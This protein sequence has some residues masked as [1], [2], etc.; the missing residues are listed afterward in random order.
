MGLAASQ[1][2]LLF[3]TSRQSD[4]SAQMQRISQQNIVLAR[5]SDEVSNTYDRMIA[6]A[7]AN[8]STNSTSASS[9]TSLVSSGS[10]PANLSYDYMMGE[11]GAATGKA[12]Y[13]LTDTSNRVVLS[14]NM[15]TKLG[16]SGTGTGHDFGKKIK[17]EEFLQKIAGS[18][19]ANAYR[20][21]S[22]GSAYQ[23]SVSINYLFS[24]MSSGTYVSPLNVTSNA[25]TFNNLARSNNAIN[26]FS[27]T[28]DGISAYYA[29]D[30]DLGKYAGKNW[31][32]AR[33]FNIS[34]KA[35]S[36]QELYNLAGNLQSSAML[37]S[38]YRASATSLPD[39]SGIKTNLGSLVNSIGSQ[40]T[41]G[42]AGL[43][44]NTDAVSSAVKTSTQAVSASYLNNIYWDEGKG[45]GDT[46]DN[47]SKWKAARES[48][49]KCIENMGGTWND[50]WS[51]VFDDANQTYDESAV[52]IGMIA[53]TNL[54]GI[55]ATRCSDEGSNN[56]WQF[57]V[58]AG[59]LVKD[60]VE[61]LFTSLSKSSGESIY[62]EADYSGNKSVNRD[63]FVTL[64]LTAPSGSSADNANL[65]KA[66]YYLKIYDQLIANGWTVDADADDM[67]K[68]Q[69]KIKNYTYKINGSKYTNSDSV[70]EVS[71]NTSSGTTGKTY[72]K[73]QAERYY[74]REKGKIQKKEKQ[75]ETEL[76][77]LQTEYS[78]L[79]N[80]YESVK[81]IISANVQKSFTYCSNG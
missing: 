74:E 20:N 69:E 59:N 39:L 32:N 6:S 71:N 36:I 16:L 75:L 21:S 37:G 34:K 33:Q 3:I 61:N 8:E 41:V 60:I 1:A 29:D 43:G 52:A 22:N 55:V 72:T 38:A 19:V 27:E 73:E 51:K 56:T 81:S 17:V 48:A 68:L 24:H 11:A 9:G 15:A 35:K 49:K 40:L 58:N 26:V 57:T 5:D 66:N 64:K 12:P 2:R 67:N 77:K 80:D 79:T 70:D 28:A 65:T 47:S 31:R 78:S 30:Y 44:L 18:D 10:S 25:D 50:D 4:V 7:E 54:H 76:T 53:A 13:I 45:D 42:L 23:K 14:S 63:K 62:D 46:F